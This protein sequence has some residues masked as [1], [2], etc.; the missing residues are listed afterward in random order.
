MDAQLDLNIE[1]DDDGEGLY[2]EKSNTT[3]T[4]D[5]MVM[6]IDD[7]EDERCHEEINATETSKVRDRKNDDD[8]E[9]LGEENDATETS[10]TM[11]HEESHE[12]YTMIT[13]QIRNSNNEN[14]EKDE[15]LSE[16]RYATRTSKSKNE[17]KK[18]DETTASNQKPKKNKN[19]SYWKHPD[20]NITNKEKKMMIA[21][22]LG[23]ICKVIM[24]NHV[25]SFGGKTFLQDG[26]GCIGDEAIGVIA[27][28]V[29]M[30]WSGE[31]KDK[32]KDLNIINHLLKVFIDDVNGVFN[33]LPP[34]TEFKDGRLLI[35]PE[36]E[37][38]DK[39]RPADRVT[40]EVIQDIANGIDDM[41]KMTIDV[42]SNHAIKRVPMLDV[43]VWINDQDK[44]KIY[45]SFYEKPTKS[46]FVI[47]KS[48]AMP[49]KKKIE[50]LSQETFRRLH[51]TKEEVNNEE[52]VEIMNKY[53]KEL[54]M[55]GY[56]EHDRF[57]I[58][59]SGYN[60][61]ENLK[62]KEKDG[63]RPFYRCRNFERKQRK[64]E[65]NTKK[66]SWY[67]EK[68][69]K[70]QKFSSVFF[71]PSTPGSKLLKMLKKTEEENK[72]D[73]QSRIKFIETSGR[74]YID[75]LR[76]NDPFSVNCKP[77]EK[78][79]VC[80]ESDKPTNCKVANIGYS[81]I[82]QTCKERNIEKTYEGESCRSGYLRQ[83]EHVRDFNNRNER[84]PMF[85]HVEK[86][87]SHE[88]DSVKFKMKIVGRFKSAMNRQID[89]GLR[90]Q[91]KSPHSLLNS[92]AEFHGPSIKRKV[93]E[94]KHR[95]RE[96]E[97]ASKEAPENP[98]NTSFEK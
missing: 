35:N 12:E 15:G 50:C 81:I 54:K 73:D 21:E 31:L 47:S 46:P 42:P 65:K 57:Q 5:T 60:N 17:D 88:K 92:K 70:A 90:I 80:E 16:D 13:Q 23:I 44:N 3:E 74:K 29:M 34:G 93:L 76:I 79:L 36:K 14:K 40:M 67:K 75:H 52:K 45:F 61:Y 91:R 56:N 30:W 86:E 2:E 59:K 62:R 77:E 4:S 27:L 43:Q 98:E 71:V 58:I 72:I 20:R 39:N 10:T 69:N 24:S 97:M 83:L 96:D 95:K 11:F 1:K 33:S 9:V 37:E 49:I 68:N 26:K 28:V 19:K 78:C 66:T 55:S 22:S 94:G 38:E 64:E 84:S 25:Y 7:D 82:C 48:S 89:E 8:E 32:L 18:E 41:I 63:I 51:N 87:H 6:V 85:K 53:M